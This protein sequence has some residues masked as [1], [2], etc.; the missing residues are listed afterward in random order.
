MTVPTAVDVQDLDRRALD[1]AGEVIAQ[2]TIADLDRPTPCAAWNL[3]E[4][5]WHMVGEN[6]SFAAAVG[7]RAQW[8]IE[9][10]GDLGI[11]PLRACH[12]S[13]AAVT[14]AFARSPSWQAS[15]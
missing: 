10:G 5:L 9:D 8:S 12:D 2:V 14:A 13:A 1:I 15:C 3:G 4:L 11:D 7:T 6:R